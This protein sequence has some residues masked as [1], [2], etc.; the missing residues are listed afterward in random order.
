M[1]TNNQILR[2]LNLVF[3]SK[4]KLNPL[5]HSPQRERGVG[6]FSKRDYPIEFPAV[7]TPLFSLWGLEDTSLLLSGGLQ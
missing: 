2:G 4:E 7:D 1:K 3:L 6:S 5:T